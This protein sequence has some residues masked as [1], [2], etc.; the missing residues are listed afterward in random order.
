MRGALAVT[1][2][3]A[4]ICSV[5]FV[6]CGSTSDDASGSDAG[7]SDARADGSSTADGSAMVDGSADSGAGSDGSTL[8]VDD[9]GFYNSEIAISVVEGVAGAGAGFSTPAPLSDVCPDIAAGDCVLFD[10]GGGQMHGYA[11]DSESAGTLTISGGTPSDVVTLTLQADHAYEGFAADASVFETGTPVTFMGTGA[12]VPAFSQT[13]TLP[14]LPTLTSPTISSGTLTIDR[15][16]DFAMTWSG[17]NADVVAVSILSSNKQIACEFPATA[18]SGVIPSTLLTHLS[19]GSAQMS[20][21][22]Y[23]KV[24]A[25]EGAYVVRFQAGLLL[26]SGAVVATL[27]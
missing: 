5:T 20:F 23:A 10:C 24:I 6:A 3:A 2:I 21:L 22:A 9:G 13:L 27:N 19:A 8:H 15:T 11:T 12:A 26:D 17:G 16:T 7:E 18:S 25:N 14:S 4:S 1:T